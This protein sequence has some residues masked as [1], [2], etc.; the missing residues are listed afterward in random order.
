MWWERQ[1]RT[2][3]KTAS[4]KKDKPP[5]EKKQ[6]LERSKAKGTNSDGGRPSIGTWAKAQ[7]CL[8]I[9]KEICGKVGV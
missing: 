1:L 7:S 9:L 2:V 5:A 8:Q 3:T 6:L 4:M